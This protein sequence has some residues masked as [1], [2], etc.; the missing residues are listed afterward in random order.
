MA[1]LQEEIARRRTLNVPW[2][3]SRRLAL[4]LGLL[5]LSLI[6]MVQAAQPPELF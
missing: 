3:S 6:L 5:V 4:A 1:H 2:L